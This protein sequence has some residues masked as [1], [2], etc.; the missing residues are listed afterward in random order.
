MSVKRIVDTSLW[1]NVRLVNEFSAEDKYF[2][3]YI[4][5]NQY[6]RQCG[7]YKL[8]KRI[9]SFE[10]GYT[11]EAIE[12][13]LDR[14]QNAYEIIIYD[15]G[16][17][18]IAI[19]SYLKHA[20]VKGGKPVYDCLERDYSDVVNKGLIGMVY[21]FLEPHFRR[22]TKETDKIIEK[23]ILEQISKNHDTSTIRPRYADN[24][25]ENENENEND[26]D[27]ENENNKIAANA[28]AREEE[29]H[30]DGKLAAA[31]AEQND[32]KDLVRA[33]EDEICKISPI[34]AQDLEERYKQIGKELLH[35]CIS[36]AGRNKGG[37]WK[38]VD[39]IAQR[40]VDTNIKTVEEFHDRK[41]AHQE[42]R[43]K[44]QRSYWS[45]DHNG[46]KKKKN[47]N[48]IMMN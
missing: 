8:P 38:Y 31:A 2:M 25:N 17:N 6:V 12:C 26:N 11:I 27:N 3:L 37:S 39:K 4:L 45:E 41:K 16:T 15:H 29:A 42:R 9:I 44:Q 33:F 46:K 20:I 32:L 30:A 1:S 14:F 7:I 40:C 36:E 19:L 21:D 23:I 5:T 22:S 47:Y 24:D 35:E 18:E 28:R 34:V 43:Q 13:I 48:D 10:M